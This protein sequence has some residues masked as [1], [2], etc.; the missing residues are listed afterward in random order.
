MAK[1]G[2]DHWAR[3]LH[4]TPRDMA[5]AAMPMPIA[6]QPAPKESREAPSHP[7][8]PAEFTVTM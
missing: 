1:R 3:N 5:Y 2:I 7:F 8:H 4:T 6:R